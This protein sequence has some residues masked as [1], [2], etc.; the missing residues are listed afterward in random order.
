MLYQR[1]FIKNAIRG[2]FTFCTD[3]N[4][5][6]PYCTCDSIS[7]SL[8]K[9]CHFYFALF[10]VP[11]SVWLLVSSAP[12]SPFRNLA[13]SIALVIAI[14]LFRSGGASSP[15]RRRAH[16]AA[17]EWRARK[18]YCEQFVCNEILKFERNN[19]VHKCV[20]PSCFHS[21]Y[22]AMPL[23]DG[24]IDVPRYSAFSR[25]AAREGSELRRNRSSWPDPEECVTDEERATRDSLWSGDD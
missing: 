19:C 12:M 23:E 21:I 25:C 3:A 2:S 8:V 14:V 5:R 6:R 4:S 11:L 22:S 16:K 9:A 1:Y 13:V 15:R 17:R 7:R 18:S 20:S 10:F 24:E